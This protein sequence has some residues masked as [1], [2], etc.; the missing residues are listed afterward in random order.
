MKKNSGKEIPF[1]L[2]EDIKKQCLPPLPEAADATAWETTAR[3]AIAEL[4]QARE[5]GRMPEAPVS[6]TVTETRTV[7]KF[8]AGSA[9]LTY[10]TL[11]A[12]IHGG[13]VC[14]FPF[15]AAVPKREEKVPAFVFLNFRPAVFDDYLPAEEIMDRGYAVFGI[16]YEDVSTDDGDFTTGIAPVL[17]PD[18]TAPDAPGKLMLWA[19]AASRVMDHIATR[20]DI[21]T[22]RVAVI[23][24]SRLGKT[25][26][27]AGAYDRRFTY[28]ISNDSGC[29]GAAPEG[30]RTEKSENRAFITRTF[31]FW[32]C[33][34]FVSDIKEG[35]EIPFDQHYLLSLI[36]PR[37]LL[38][39]SAEE[40]LWAAPTAEFL[41]TYA[42]A[43]I[44]RLYGKPGLITPDAYPK[45]P[46]DLSEGGAAYHVRHGVHYLSRRDWLSYMDY[47]DRHKRI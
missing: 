8:A 37:A 22:A 40:D 32:F 11:E 41:G 17:C 14:R 7:T 9:V 46:C 28:V 27:L 36:P 31:P 38:V 19:W 21:D 39:G 33:P 34:A 29:C 45:A 15:Y 47:I 2:Y 23:G 44:Y 26:L 20:G 3:P 12:A 30:G 5:Y 35:K 25:A 1:M 43:E 6:V 4:L 13:G 24:H 18:R 16:H 42:T 10:Y